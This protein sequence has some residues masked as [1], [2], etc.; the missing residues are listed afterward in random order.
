MEI[1]DRQLGRAMEA[2]GLPFAS[3]CRLIAIPLQSR[4]LLWRDAA[5]HLIFFGRYPRWTIPIRAS[6]CSPGIQVNL[7]AGRHELFRGIVSALPEISQFSPIN[8]G[9]CRS[10]AAVATPRCGENHHGL[11]GL[12]LRHVE[13]NRPACGLRTMPA[14]GGDI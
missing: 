6:A 1:H 4:Q 14:I 12:H 13:A 11:F 2:A 8:Q 7:P 9:A 3:A 5:A 10:R